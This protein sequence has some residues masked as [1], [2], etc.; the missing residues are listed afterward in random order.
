MGQCS[1]IPMVRAIFREDS[2]IN[3]QTSDASDFFDSIRVYVREQLTRSL[4]L[5][6]DGRFPTVEDKIRAMFQQ[7]NEGCGLSYELFLRQFSGMVDRVFPLGHPDRESAVKIAN[8]VG[9]YATQEE[10]DEDKMDGCMHGLDP[11]CCP[12]GCGD[13]D[14]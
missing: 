4:G 12:C 14:G 1:A 11:D 7:A 9:G 2:K 10:L 5:T 8:A 13:M 3:A 6:P